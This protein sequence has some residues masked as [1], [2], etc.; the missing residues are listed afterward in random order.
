MAVDDR[1]PVK[2]DDLRQQ[3]GA[4]ASEPM[5]ALQLQELEAIELAKN[6]FLPKLEK[7]VERLDDEAGEW[8][9]RKQAA[10]MGLEIVSD[11]LRYNQR[12]NDSLK[13][14]MAILKMKAKQGAAEEDPNALTAEQAFITGV[15][16]GK[17]SKAKKR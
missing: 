10:D 12:W 7:I 15:K 11:Y 13:T 1:N 14:L 8:K 16:H 9:E 3:L 5:V 4:L 17:D 6:D 2:V